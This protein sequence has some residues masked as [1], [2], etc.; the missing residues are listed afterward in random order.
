MRGCVGGWVCV[1]TCV[2]VRSSCTTLTPPQQTRATSSTANAL[3]ELKALK[4]QV[5]P[6][7]PPLPACACKVYARVTPLPLQRPDDFAAIVGSA[8]AATAQVQARA[9][10]TVVCLLQPPPFDA[11]VVVV[12]ADWFHLFLCVD[13]ERSPAVRALPS[14]ACSTSLPPLLPEASQLQA[15]A[16]VRARAFDMCTPC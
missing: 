15:R 9:R 4:R 6:A 11:N 13:D 5:L 12:A 14:L 10:V 3:Q 2:R 16:A 7:P 8:H 1:G